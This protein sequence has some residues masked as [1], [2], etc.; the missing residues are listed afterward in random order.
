MNKQEKALTRR[1]FIKKGGTLAAATALAGLA[2]GI[3]AGKAY[4]KVPTINFAYILSD[5]HAP[6]M[7]LARDW[8]LFQE[9]YK[10]CLKPVREYKLYDFFYEGSKIARVKLIPTKKGPD[11]EKL[12]AQGSVDMGISG[13]QAILMSIDK[14]VKTKIISPLQ[15]A[16]NVFV[17]KKELPMNNWSEFEIGR[18]SC[19]ERV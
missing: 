5:H 15:N 8:E 1:D 2:P 3:I 9:R 12:V 11:L 18:A 16:G 17:L 19:R 7:V 10:T 13:T 14:G 6:L 4:A